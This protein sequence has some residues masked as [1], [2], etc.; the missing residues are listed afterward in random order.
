MFFDPCNIVKLRE[1]SGKAASLE[2]KLKY[3]TQEMELLQDESAQLQEQNETVFSY[4]FMLLFKFENNNTMFSWK[5]KSQ[6]NQKRWK[7][8]ARKLPLC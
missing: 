7:P 4:F 3:Q 2:D 6:R 8:C 5:L 1:D